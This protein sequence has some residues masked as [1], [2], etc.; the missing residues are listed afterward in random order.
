MSEENDTD[1]SVLCDKHL[2]KHNDPKQAHRCIRGF[3]R[4]G[5]D[6]KCADIEIDE[7]RHA[8][9]RAEALEDIQRARMRKKDGD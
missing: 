7:R 2:C 8:H 4:I 1:M 3:I 5:I 6:G 9:A